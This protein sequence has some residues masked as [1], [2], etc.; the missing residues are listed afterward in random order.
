MTLAHT[1]Q[2]EHVEE[3]KEQSVLSSNTQPGKKNRQ[4]LS[5]EVMKEIAKERGGRCLSRN[6]VNSAT[7]LN[8][9]CSEGH[10]W[11]A[12]ANSIRSGTWCPKCSRKGGNRPSLTIDQMKKL[13]FERGG[14]CLSEAYQGCHM[15]LEWECEHG[16]VWKASASSVRAGSWCPSCYHETRRVLKYTIEDMKKLA[17]S[18]GGTCLSPAY[19]G[20]REHLIWQ[21][22]SGHTWKANPNSIRSGS[23]CP[24]C[25]RATR[26]ERIWKPYREMVAQST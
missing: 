24:D 14:H 16:H 9:K 8:W 5:I 11:K 12:N 26:E 7:K 4:K 19:L 6:Y 25:E 1:C 18:N 21:C 2:H 15:K 23:W 17:A 13:A 22:N 10:T 20:V 3:K